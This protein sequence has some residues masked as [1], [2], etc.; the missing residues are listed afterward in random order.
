MISLDRPASGLSS[1]FIN[2]EL[3]W[4]GF[5]SRVLAQAEDRAAPLLERVKFCAIYSSNLDEFFQVRVAG[6]TEQVAAGVTKTPPDGLSPGD[7][8]SAIRTEVL[9]QEA[10]VRAVYDELV[11]LLAA[12]GIEIL[13]VDEL[14][15]AEATTATAEFESHIFPVLTPLAVDSSHPF[16]Y[17]S[18]LSLNLGVLIDD[19]DL[20]SLCFARIKVPPT[21]PRFLT[22]APGRVVPAEQVI[23]AHLDQLFPG[24][25]VVGAWSFRV[26]RNADLS[27]DDSDAD[28]LIEAIED[29]LKRRSKFGRAVRL[30]MDPA[31]PKVARDLLR[32]E[33]GLSRDQV[34]E[35]PT[36]LDLTGLWEIANLERPEL[37]DPPRSSVTPHRLRNIAD[38]EDFFARIAQADVIV[39][40]PYDSFAASTTEL[41]RQ[42]SLDPRVLAIK[43]TLYRTSGDSPII[44][45]LIRAAEQGKQVAALIELRA[46]F[47]EEANITWARR[48]EQAGVHVVYGLAGL[49]IH[50]KTALVVRDEPDG[51]RRYCHVGTGNYNPK[52]ARLYED[53]GILTA[54]PEIGADLS[55]LF[56]YLTGYGRSVTYE[57]LLV[58]PHSLRSALVDLVESEIEAHRRHGGGRIIMKMNSLVDAEM[59]DQLYA[60]SNAGVEI[61]LIVRGI[62]CLRAGVP[63]LSA[64]IRV[65]SIVGRYLEHSRVFYFGNGGGAGVDRWYI[66][67]ADIMPRNLDRRVEVMVRVDD[68]HSRRQLAEAFEVNLADTKLAWE[69]QPDGTYRRLG[70]DVDSHRLFEELADERG[71]SP[72]TRAPVAEEHTIRAA[73]CLVYRRGPDG[74]EVLVTHRPRYDDW[75]LPKGK[76]DPGET[77]IECALREVEEETGFRGE[78]GRE[79][80]AATYEVGGRPK[81]VR[82]WLLLATEGEFSPN[83]EVDRIRW[84][85][86]A[87]AAD[88]LAYEHD[89]RLLDELPTE[90]L[91][92]R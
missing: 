49:K 86:A 77:D 3:S 38:S 34:Y 26:T 42:A 79:L 17:I 43:L 4:L 30:E 68:Q 63:G 53:F 65:R 69:L 81:I 40:H 67:S 52:T 32:R 55:H 2:R 29:E 37:K 59:I 28:D 64:N 80:P 56:N 92:D 35:T 87:E 78:I 9:A 11:P 57:R 82:Y 88:L 24:V 1:R 50:T 39:H 6:L 13:D 45:S 83:E 25:E 74:P 44:G 19:P 51:V 23:A 61:D 76:R 72:A 47:D 16:P 18:N 31:M 46:R 89:R 10:R 41:I 54:D 60:A 20:A 22:V 48:L 14:S 8:L 12:A 62:C 73:G 70:G 66:G 71:S 58:A 85:T 33:L 21:S 84:V 90:L 91:V 7:Q 15:P 27:F 5:N 36:P 75:S